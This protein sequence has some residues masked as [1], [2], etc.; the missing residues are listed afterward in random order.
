MV[1]VQLPL[2]ND[3]PVDGYDERYKSM[4]IHFADDYRMEIYTDL[5]HLAGRRGF[6]VYNKSG[7]I[8]IWMGLGDIDSKLEFI[9]FCLFADFI[10]VARREIRRVSLKDIPIKEKMELIKKRIFK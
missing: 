6:D 8:E 7:I 10:G 5:K 3:F 4:N 9:T 1:Y 2:F